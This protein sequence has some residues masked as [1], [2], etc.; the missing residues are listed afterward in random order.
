MGVLSATSAVTMCMVKGVYLSIKKPRTAK[1]AKKHLKRFDDKS[2]KF[3]ELLSKALMGIAAHTIISGRY[4]IMHPGSDIY[5]D[6]W[7]MT[8]VRESGGDPTKLGLAF[9]NRP[10]ITDNELRSMFEIK[11]G[12]GRSDQ[13]YQLEKGMKDLQWYLDNINREGTVPNTTTMPYTPGSGENGEV[14]VDQD[15]RLRWET[16]E[17][18]GK[19]TGVIQYVFER[20]SNGVW[21]TVPND[22]KTSVGILKAAIDGKNSAAPASNPTP[23]P[24]VTPPD[25]GTA[26]QNA[27]MPV[28]DFTSDQGVPSQGSSAAPQNSQPIQQSTWRKAAAELSSIGAGVALT[29]YLG[30][31]VA[32]VGIGV[33]VQA[34]FGLFTIP[35]RQPEA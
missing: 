11:P 4:K 24:G 2:S 10:D 26:P 6:R 34:E 9:N 15:T 31:T 19:G 29:A 14:M 22:I 28:P 1:D 7:L 12:L 35:N 33:F 8:I 25:P 27:A 16:A 32:K 23:G 3:K 18:D 17:R 5:I 20:Q 21:E 13:D 30:Y